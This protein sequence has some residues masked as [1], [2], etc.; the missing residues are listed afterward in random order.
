[1]SRIR[2]KIALFPK[3]SI[4]KRFH[5][6]VRAFVFRTKANECKPN[7]N[8][9][10]IKTDVSSAKANGC[11]PNTNGN[12]IKTDASRSKANGCKPN[13]NGNDVKTDAFGRKT[14]DFAKKS[15]RYALM[16]RNML[17]KKYINNQ[18][19][20]HFNLKSNEVAQ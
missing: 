11:K 6:V 3:L 2:N 19:T 7:T 15:N 5:N 16:L 8:G 4:T 10:D 20:V 1:M 12:D 17:L 18:K 9:N 14:F 13:T